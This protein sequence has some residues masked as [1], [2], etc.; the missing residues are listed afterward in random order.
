MAKKRAKKQLQYKSENPLGG[1]YQ[2]EG[3]EDPK[4]VLKLFG[5]LLV[6]PSGMRS[7]KYVGVVRAGENAYGTWGWIFVHNGSDWVHKGYTLEPRSSVGKGPIPL[8]TFP[9][10]Q[11]MSPT[12]KKTLRLSNVP[13]FTD[14]LIHV[15]NTQGDTKG[16]ILAALQVDSETAPTQLI[17]SRPLVDWL[18]DNCAQGTVQVAST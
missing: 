8:G 9:Y 10:I 16:C 6:S 14:I 4:R 15:G 2:F 18:Y 12:L 7:D 5:H 13:D 17:S 1:P 3:F 11:W